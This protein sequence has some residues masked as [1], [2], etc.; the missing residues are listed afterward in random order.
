MPKSTRD[1]AKD[2]LNRDMQRNVVTDPSAV[3]GPAQAGSGVKEIIQPI[4]IFKGKK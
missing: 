4:V 2:V 3:Q 1:A